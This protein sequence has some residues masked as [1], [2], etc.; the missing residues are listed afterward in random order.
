MHVYLAGPIALCDRGEANDWRHD[1]SAR[2]DAFGVVGVS[3]LRCEPLVGDK[4]DLV[5]EDVRFGTPKAIA[6][7][8]Y[9]DTK[10]CDLI[11]AY[12]PQEINERRPSYGTVIEIGWAQAFSKPIILVTDDPYLSKHPLI[13]ARVNWIV[14][15]F[16]DAV[17]V[18]EGLLEVYV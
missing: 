12:L 5:Y 11:L 6:G 17:D 15:D 13:A 16:D 18:I 10:Q 2:L 7:K 4:Y 3:P 14:E 8:N 9:F 1:I